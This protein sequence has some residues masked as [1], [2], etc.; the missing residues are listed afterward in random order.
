MPVAYALIGCWIFALDSGKCHALASWVSPTII[1]RHSTDYIYLRTLRFA[2]YYN[3]LWK[4]VLQ[5]GKVFALF[6]CI[7]LGEREDLVLV[8]LADNLCIN[9]AQ[10]FFEMR[11]VLFC[12]PAIYSLTNIVYDMWLVHC[13]PNNRTV[14][15]HSAPTRSR[16]ALWIKN[17]V[18]A[19]IHAQIHTQS[20]LLLYS[21]VL[22]WLLHSDIPK[23]D[24]N[25]WYRGFHLDRTWFGITKVHFVLVN[26]HS[27][28]YYVCI[29]A[30]R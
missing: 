21:G 18:L 5:P 2:L 4:P 17:T 6:T 3:H 20:V 13:R 29:R 11:Y 26:I 10:T 19:R 12:I 28:T 22:I 15:T 9:F 1:L 7:C 25:Q 23:S 27:F 14:P 30:P 8:F 24:K 16:L